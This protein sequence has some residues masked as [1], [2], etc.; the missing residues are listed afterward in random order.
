MPLQP[1]RECRHAVS[2]EAQACPSCGAVQPAGVSGGAL[3]LRDPGAPPTP[4]SPGAHGPS[5]EFWRA[6]H[7][8]FRRV[9]IGLYGAGSGL[10][11]AILTGSLMLRPGQ[12]AVPVGLLASL[13]L[14]LMAIVLELLDPHINKGGAND[15]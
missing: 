2:T 13:V 10:F 3:T 5:P 6:T 4:A 9:R 14:C 15:H 1:C 12:G 11:A 8:V 7:L